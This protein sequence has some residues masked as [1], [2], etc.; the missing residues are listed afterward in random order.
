[1]RKPDRASLCD[2]ARIEKAVECG[3]VGF[4]GGLQH[5]KSDV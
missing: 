3:C 1:M 2:Q 4:L 5:S